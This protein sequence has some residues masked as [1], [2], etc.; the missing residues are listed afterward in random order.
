MELRDVGGLWGFRLEEG[1]KRGRGGAV[2]FG[3]FSGVGVTEMS[4]NWTG[5][6]DVGDG[7]RSECKEDGVVGSGMTVGDVAVAEDIMVHI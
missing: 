1:G 7:E 6:V 3:G 2:D 5:G 4:I